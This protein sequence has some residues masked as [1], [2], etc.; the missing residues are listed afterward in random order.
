[1][2]ID[3]NNNY[4]IAGE[5]ML[6]TSI[7]VDSKAISDKAYP[8]V[9]VLISNDGMHFVIRKSAA[10]QSEVIKSTLLNEPDCVEIMLDAPSRVLGDIVYRMNYNVGKTM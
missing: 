10:E 9:I 7:K 8:Q 3:L 4:S 6:V 1:M 2:P 5:A